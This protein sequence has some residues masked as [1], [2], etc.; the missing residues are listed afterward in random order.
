MAACE[1]LIVATPELAARLKLPV[2]IDLNG[3]FSTY[4]EGLRW[5]WSTYKDRLSRHLCNFKHPGLLRNCTFAYDYQWRGLLFWIA[6]T[7]DASEPGA[8]PSAEQRVV[9]EILSEMAVN[10]PVLGFPFAGKGVGVGEPPGV[11]LISRYGKGLVCTDHFANASVTSGMRIDRFEQPQQPSTPPLEKDKIYIALVLSDGDNQNCWTAFFR[12]YFEHPSFGTFPL[13]FGMGPPIQELMPGIAQWYFEHAKPTTEFIADVSGV[14]YIQPDR[15]AEAY[16]DR[17]RVYAGYVDW[18][19]KLMRPLGMRSLRTVGGG[20]ESITRFAHGLP[21][22]H[23]I[24]ADM[25][26]YSGHEGIDNLTYAL[27]DGMPVFRSVTSWRY[28]KEGFLKEI[29]E[30]VGNKRPAFV[31]G[32]VHC[33]TFGPEDLARIYHQRDAD[34]VFVTPSQ[35]AALYR[36]AR[37]KGWAK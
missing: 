28:G 6:G 8:D 20:D 24:F 23:S 2:K 35:L 16:A 13:A 21:W 10:T 34:M 9:A 5:L 18:T 17:E 22:C 4:A 12:R 26:R 32:F 11:A 3:R 27:P 30:Q 36:Q 15:Y 1:D 31:N 33:W 14:A 19:A 25:G 37:D 29:R 7:V